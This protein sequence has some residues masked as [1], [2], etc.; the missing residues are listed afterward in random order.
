MALSDGAQMASY[1]I[2]GLLGA[3]GMGEKMLGVGGLILFGR[4]I[5][6]DKGAVGELQGQGG[7]P[8]A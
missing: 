2:T 1:R 5:V 4:A 3:G 8:G 6:I 7:F